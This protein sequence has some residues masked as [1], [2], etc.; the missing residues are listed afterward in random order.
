M[1][2]ENL[3]AKRGDNIRAKSAV[4][5]SNKIVKAEAFFMLLF[6]SLKHWA[7]IRENIK[8]IITHFIYSIFIF[9]FL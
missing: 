6:V 7:N 2:S 8:Y 9:P 1:Y 5:T 4:K 3:Y